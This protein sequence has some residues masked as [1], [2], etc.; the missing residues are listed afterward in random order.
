MGGFTLS[1]LLMAILL[2]IQILNFSGSHSIYSVFNPDEGCF[3]LILDHQD[4]ADDFLHMDENEEAHFFHNSCC[5]NDLALTFKKQKADH[6]LPFT[7]T[8]PNHKFELLSD[9]IS[10]PTTVH[11]VPFPPTDSVQ[12]LQITR[13]LI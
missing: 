7:Y 9:R 5:F 4:D 13:L 6:A 10:H 11:L 8:K 1:W 2:P 12:K 3:E